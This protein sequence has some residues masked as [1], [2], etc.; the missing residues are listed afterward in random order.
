MLP[1]ELYIEILS[2]VFCSH[3]PLDSALQ[4]CGFDSSSRRRAN[5]D[6]HVIQRRQMASMCRVSRAFRD[7]LR[8]LLY[9]CTVLSGSRLGPYIL[10]TTL[11]RKPHLARMVK[12][13][14][15][16]PATCPFELDIIQPL[17][18]RCTN[19]AIFYDFTEYTAHEPNMPLAAEFIELPRRLLLDRLCAGPCVARQLSAL[20][21]LCSRL[22]SLELA[23]TST[24]NLPHTVS[25]PALKA[26][27]IPVD[28]RTMHHC[29]LPSLVHLYIARGRAFYGV[30]AP[31]SVLVLEWFRSIGKQIK[32][33]ELGVF[34]MVDMGE[35]MEA[36]FP[37]LED[38]RVRIDIRTGWDEPKWDIPFCRNGPRHSRV[39]TVGL[40][41]IDDRIGIADSHPDAYSR[42]LEGMVIRHFGTINRDAFPMLKTVRDLDGLPHLG[43]TTI[44]E[45]RWQGIIAT[46]RSQHIVLR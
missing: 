42:G 31:T 35:S 23:A 40:H 28:D 30:D 34:S 44:Q 29:S 38:F 21:A 8:P 24:A 41:G 14:V 20:P 25:L 1:L 9:R 39:A 36:L 37:S 15:L 17:F 13:I 26:L 27:K 19:L 2:I 12:A 5:V 43:W 45:A 46:W 22:T 10:G 6:A 32:T 18:K 16:M 7:I 11:E 4:L 33:L 3:S